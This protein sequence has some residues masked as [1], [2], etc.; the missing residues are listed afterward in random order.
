LRLR[1]IHGEKIGEFPY[2]AYHGEYVKHLA[3]RLYALEGTRVFMMPEKD[4]L[5]HL[6]EFAPLRALEM[7]RNSLEKFGVVFEGWFRKN[8]TLRRSS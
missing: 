8:F 5:E 3:H 6:K 4:R 1:E 7:Q 2:E